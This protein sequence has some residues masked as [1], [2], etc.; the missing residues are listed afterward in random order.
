MSLNRP[1][2]NNPATST[3][4]V[5]QQLAAL[6]VRDEKAASTERVDLPTEG[7]VTIF[8]CTGVKKNGEQFIVTKAYKEKSL[9]DILQEK[10]KL[11]MPYGNDVII[12]PIRSIEE[13]LAARPDNS[14][15]IV[16]IKD[17][18]PLYANGKEFEN[19]INNCLVEFT[20]SLEHIGTEWI[21]SSNSKGESFAAQKMNEDV[22]T[23]FKALCDREG[24]PC[25]YIQE[26]AAI[27]FDDCYEGLVLRKL[28]AKQEN[29]LSLTAGGA[30][31]T[32]VTTN[33]TSTT[34][35][36]TTSLKLGSA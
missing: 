10:T 11:R 36:S 9:T 5:S 32:D 30:P 16:T 29:N 12:V 28:N 35:A 14:S 1:S 20:R 31:N 22:F 6:N 17:R 4:M 23:E 33:S 21:G 25:E 13:T 15:S 19:D 2:S 34:V 24:I 26:H 3:A 18:F 27:S 8:Y 7:N